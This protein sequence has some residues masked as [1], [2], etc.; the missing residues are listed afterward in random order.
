MYDLISKTIDKQFSKEAFRSN[1]FEKDDLVSDLYL[2]LSEFDKEFTETEL[3]EIIKKKYFNYFEIYDIKDNKSFDKYENGSDAIV[4]LIKT[5]LASKE[6]TKI[7]E[8]FENIIWGKDK[9]CPKCRSKEVF[10]SQNNIRQHLCRNCGNEFSFSQG[11]N[12]KYA[13]ITSLKNIISIY[14]LLEK[15]IICFREIQDE[16]GMSKRELKSAYYKNIPNLIN[17]EPII[18]KTEI[19]PIAKKKIDVNFKEHEHQTRVIKEATEYF[20]DNDR[21][22]IIHPCGSGKTYTAIKIAQNLNPKRLLVVIPSRVLLKQQIEVFLPYFENH[23]FYAFGSLSKIKER[24]IIILGETVEKQKRQ[25]KHLN[26]SDNI[27]IFTTLTSFANMKDDFK[28]NFFD[29]AIFDEAHRVAGED[30]KCFLKVINFNNYKKALFLTATEKNYSEEGAVGMNNDLFGKTISKIYMKEMIDKGVICDY[31]I[32]NVGFTS[33]NVAEILKENKEFFLDVKVKLPVKTRILMSALSLVK[34]IE[35]YPLKKI[36]TYHSTIEESVLFINI[37]N[38]FQKKYG[39][40]HECYNLHSNQNESNFQYNLYNFIRSEKAV[41]SS[42]NCFQEGMDIVDVDA[43]LYAYPK[44]SKIDIPQSIGRCVRKYPN[45]EKGY[46]IIPDEIGNSHEYKKLIEVINALETVDNRIE[47]FKVKSKKSY[48]SK[49]LLF[50]YIVSSAN[51]IFDVEKF[52][53]SL[54]FRLRGRSFLS[55]E[56]ARDYI[57]KNAPHIKTEKDYKEWSKQKNF[58]GFLYKSPR[59]EDFKWPYYL[60][61][62]RN[63]DE[64]AN[65]EQFKK[66]LTEN[67]ISKVRNFVELSKN[68]PPEI[69]VNFKYVYGLK[70]AEIVGKPIMKITNLKNI[71]SYS[72]AKK[73]C[74]ENKIDSQKSYRIK[75]A[76]EENEK[77]PANPN[78]LYKEEWEG[79]EKFIGYKVNPILPYKEAKLWI[80]ENKSTIKTG[81]DYMEWAY[82]KDSTFPLKALPK[83]PYSYYKEEWVGWKDFL[84][85]KTYNYIEISNWCKENNI[86]TRKEYFERKKL[87]FPCRPDIFFK[88][89]QG[90]QEFLSLE[91][92]SF[93][94][95]KKWIRDNKINIEVDSYTKWLKYIRKQD[96]TH[97]NFNPLIPKHPKFVYKEKWV[98]WD[99]FLNRK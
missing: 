97:L 20:S 29:F 88:E 94:D 78:R 10:P 60:T 9:S 68:F 5:P 85:L 71:L 21:G 7:Y 75:V 62:R 84:N 89:W 81:K 53:N 39:L 64:F 11:T 70:W 61:S 4:N 38:L 99:D 40:S 83:S 14:N 56:D 95:C 54:D 41:I 43:V 93:E 47:D 82:K 55:Y 27:V 25:I 15:G 66:Y 8:F 98:S 50:D 23:Q 80:K 18:Q 52:Y 30:Y 57:T 72:E 45:K 22:K 96:Y 32:I 42:V 58:P 92:L 87:D 86:K 49:N 35:K 16:T 90:W 13:D 77:L 59:Y 24:K 37:F 79:W 2:Y 6:E 1:F 28:E 19:V 36:I 65:I 31:N 63:R 46:V 69:P 48:F 67:N 3:L 26:A 91:K 44:K 33:D 73:W 12:L 51:E 74:R 76:L 34:C 17:N